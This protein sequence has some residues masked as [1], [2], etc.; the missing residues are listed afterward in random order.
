M[1]IAQVF[2][3]MGDLEQAMLKLRDGLETALTI[4]STTLRIY[5]L[6]ECTLLWW[7]RGRGAEAAQWIGLLQEN[8]QELD[9]EQKSALADVQDKLERELGHAQLGQAI[10]AGK[11]LE[12]NTVMETMMEALNTR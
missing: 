9:S 10:D 7:D 6:L 12:L 3:M 11:G 1:Q 8:L 4:Q 2:R 5:Y